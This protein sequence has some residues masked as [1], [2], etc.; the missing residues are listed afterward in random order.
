[1]AIATG[2]RVRGTKMLPI[3]NMPLPGPFVT[4][5]V[6]ALWLMALRTENRPGFPGRPECVALAVAYAATSRISENSSRS[7]PP[8]TATVSPSRTWP[9]RIR[10]ASGS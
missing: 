8:V 9:A 1:M 10:S 2:L 6:S 4:L 5:P 3:G 7:L